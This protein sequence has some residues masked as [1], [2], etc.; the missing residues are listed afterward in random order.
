MIKELGRLFDVSLYKNLAE[1]FAKDAKDV[2]E[3]KKALVKREGQL[4]TQNLTLMR[5]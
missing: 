4:S 2:V 3:K 1:K 5:S